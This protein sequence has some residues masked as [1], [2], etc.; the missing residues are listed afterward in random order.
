MSP[1]APIAPPRVTRCRWHVERAAVARCQGCG[2]MFCRE[3]VTEHD[4]RMVCA[5][6]LAKETAAEV[7]GKKPR[8]RFSAPLWIGAQIVIG[9]VVLWIVFYFIGRMLLM[10]PSGFHDFAA[11]HE[12][13]MVRIEGRAVA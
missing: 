2:G 7:E 1:A 10:L 8:K 6:C 5:D 11:C 4:L 3:C 12:A 9:V 13:S